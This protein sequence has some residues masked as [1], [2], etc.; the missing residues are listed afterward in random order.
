MFLWRPN[1]KRGNDREGQLGKWEDNQETSAS[2]SLRKMSRRSSINII[3]Y[4]GY[5]SLLTDKVISKTLLSFK[6][7]FL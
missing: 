6:D 2:G 5:R 3:Y 7:R 4:R 1:N